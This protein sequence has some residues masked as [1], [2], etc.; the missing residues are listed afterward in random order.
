VSLKSFVNERVLLNNIIIA[1]LNRFVVMLLA[2][3]QSVSAFWYF[4][5]PFTCVDGRDGVGYILE[6]VP[7]E[8]TLR[9]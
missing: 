5:L 8:D 6:I 4:I 9:T 2:W 3:F 7:F 1:Q